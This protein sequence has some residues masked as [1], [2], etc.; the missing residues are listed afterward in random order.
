METPLVISMLKPERQAV[1]KLYEGHKDDS[2]LTPRFHRLSTYHEN[3]LWRLTN[4]SNQTRITLLSHEPGQESSLHPP[5]IA[6]NYNIQDAENILY[7]SYSLLSANA[8]V[9]TDAYTEENRRLRSK[10]RRL[11]SSAWGQLVCEGGTGSSGGRFFSCSE[12][13]CI[14]PSQGTACRPLTSCLWLWR[15]FG[16]STSSSWAAQKFHLPVLRLLMFMIYPTGH[17]FILM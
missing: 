12:R 7:F 3:S 16:V 13:C 6:W 15:W 11:Q 10:V 17:W 14:C 8:V 9:L 1:G 5:V 4:S 2:I